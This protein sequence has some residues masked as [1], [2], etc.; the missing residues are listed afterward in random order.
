MRAGQRLK[1]R[2][3]RFQILIDRGEQDRVVIPSAKRMIDR[4]AAAKSLRKSR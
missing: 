4:P 1:A 2:Q 3:Q